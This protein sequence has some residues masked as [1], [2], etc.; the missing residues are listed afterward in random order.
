MYMN[1]FS[2]TLSPSLR[3]SYMVLPER[4]LTR[5][6]ETSGFYSCPVP[7]FEQLI[8]AEFIRSGEFER[9]VNR[10]RRLKRGQQTSQSQS[11]S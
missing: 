6:E 3:I 1:T 9:Y 8:L 11:Q 5:Y 4:M 10:V 7:T 2:V